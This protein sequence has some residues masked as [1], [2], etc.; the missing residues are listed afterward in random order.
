[1][2]KR[3]LSMLLVAAMLISCFPALPITWARAESMSGQSGTVVPSYQMAGNGSPS[4]KLDEDAYH[5]LGFD[6]SMGTKDESVLGPGN[7]TMNTKHEL[8]LNYNGYRNY[9]WVLRENLN[10]YHNWTSYHDAGAYKYYGQFYNKDYA[11]LNAGNGYTHGVLGG[12]TLGSYI[13]SENN[14]LTR[15]FELSTAFRSSSGKE[16][17]VAQIYINSSSVRKDFTARLELI[18]FNNGSEQIT[19]SVTLSSDLYALDEQGMFYN[20]NFDALF[21]IAAGDFNGDGIDEI[22]VYFATGDVKIYSTKYDSLSLWKTIYRSEIVKNDN[23]HKIATDGSYNH[24]VYRAP[25]VTLT[26]GDLKKDHSDDLII[27][28][29][30]PQGDGSMVTAHQNN[31]YTYIYG[32]VDGSLK[33]EK[34]I[35]LKADLDGS[36]STPQVFKG[37]NATVGDLDGNNL[38]ELVI[39]GRLCNANNPGDT[40]WNKGGL[41]LVVY[42]HASKSYKVYDPQVV[43]LNEYDEADILVKAHNGDIDYYAPVAMEIVD[44]DGNAS[45]APYL[46][47]FAELFSYNRDT[48]QFGYTGHYIDTIKN[49]TNNADESVGKGQH[50]ISD[51]VVGNLNNNDRNAQQ[52]IAI[53]GCKSSKDDTYWYYMSYLSKNENGDLFRGVEGIMN[54][55]ISCLN[56]SDK[57]RS[58]VYVSISLPDVDNDSVM[59]KYLDT[60]SVYSKPEV[61]AILQ[62]V[63]YFQ[64]V[65]DVYDNYL[66]NGT[67]AYGKASGSGY[68]KQAVVSV[69]AGYYSE[70]HISAGVASNLELTIGAFAD[71]NYVKNSETETSIEYSGD[72][73]DDYVVMYTIPYFYHYY[74]AVYPD[75][76]TNIIV[77]EEPMTPATVIVPVDTYDAIANKTGALQPIRGNILNSIPGKPMT[78]TTPPKGEWTSIGQ[79]QALTNAGASGSLVTVSHTV[80]NSEEHNFAAGIEGELKLGFGGGVGGNDTVHGF[81][82]DGSVGGG[83]V[84][85]SMEGVAYTGSVDNLPAGV[86]GYGFNWQLGISETTLNGESIIVV[87][88]VTSNVKQAPSLPKDL[89]VTDITNRSISLQWNSA[90]EAAVYELFVSRDQSTWLPLDP[91][92]ATMVDENNNMNYQVTD[93]SPGTTYYF[94]VN[95]ADAKGVRSLDSLPV[96]GT[97]LG[98]DGAFSIVF[99]PQDTSAAKGKDATFSVTVSSDSESTIY[100]QWMY[101]AGSG[102]VNIPNSNSSTLTVSNVTQDMDGYVYRC[103]VSQSANYFY[104]TGAKLTV[105]KTNIGVSLGVTIDGAA[106]ADGSTVQ[107]T[108]VTTQDVTNQIAVWND[109]VKNGY[110][111]VTP[112]QFVS[113]SDGGFSYS[114]SAIYFWMDAAGSLYQN[115]SG[116]SVG[117]KL[118]ASYVFSSESNTEFHTSASAAAV[119]KTITVDKDSEKKVSVTSGF[120]VNGSSGEYVYIHTSGDKTVYY[121]KVGTYAKEENG[122]TTNY[123]LYGIVTLNPDATYILNTGVKYLVNELDKVKA[124]ATQTIVVGQTSQTVPG[125]KLV[126]TASGLPSDLSAKDKVTFRVVHTSSGSTTNITATRNGD[127]WVG[128]HTFTGEGVYQISA[129]YSGNEVYFGCTSN[130]VTLFVY[131]SRNVMTLGGATMYYGQTLH[132][133]P[134][135]HSASGSNVVSGKVT[136]TVKQGDKDVSGLVSGGVFTPV[137]S[138]EYGITASCTVDGVQYSASA[139]I[140][141]HAKRLTI[142]ANSVTASLSDSQQQRQSLLSATVS[143]LLAA[144]AQMLSY[145]VSSD[146]VKA[147][148]QGDYRIV[149]AI[150][151]DRAAL[152]K[153]YDIVIS[154]GT[155]TLEQSSVRVYADAVANGVVVISYS[156]IVSDSTGTY[157]STPLTVNSGTLLPLGARVT[158]TASPNAGFGVEKWTLNGVISSNSGNT[159]L[160]DSLSETVDIDV[161]FTQNYSTLTFGGSDGG[162]ITGAYFGTNSS[163]NSGDRINLNQTVVL[164]AKPAEGYVVSSWTCDG[165]IVKAENGV[166]NFT[167]LSLKVS[168]VAESTVYHVNFEPAK[169]AQVTITFLD[170]D[171]Y[172]VLGGSV[173]MNQQNISGTDGVFVFDTYV[174]DNL[175]I[176][177]S[178]PGNMLIDHWELDGK[179]CANAV[180]MLEINDLAGDR[181]YV[182]YCT[183]PNQRILTLGT[184]LIE[185]NGGSLGAAGALEAMRGNVSVASGTQLPQGVVVQLVA[186]PAAGYRVTKW[187]INGVQVAGA[188]VEAYQLLL[189]QDSNVQVW[190]EKEPII[191]F[192]SGQGGN[193]NAQI[194]D[195]GVA[196]GDFVEFGSNIQVNFIPDTGYVVDQVFVDGANVTNQLRISGDVRYIILENIQRNTE[197][198]ASYKAKPVVTISGSGITVEGFKDFGAV[199]LNSGDYV[200]FGSVLSVT[201]TPISG[202]VVNTIRVNGAAVD[203]VAAVDSDVVNV[204]IDDIQTDTEISVVYKTK[205]IVSLLNPAFGQVTMEATRD[206]AFVQIQ[207]GN[208]VDFG[209]SVLCTVVPDSGYVVADVTADG[210]SLTLTAQEGTDCVTFC[211]ED[212]RKDTQIQVVYDAKPVVSVDGTDNGDVFLM[213]D[214]DFANVDISSGDYVDFGANVSG[215]V[216]PDFGFIV[217]SVTVNGVEVALLAQNGTDAVIFDV[218]DIQADT[219]I[220]VQYAAIDTTGITFGIVDKN[221]VNAD[222]GLDGTITASVDRKGMTAYAVVNDA[223]GVLAQVYSGSTVTFTAIPNDGYKVS[224]WFVNG[225][226]VSQQ[227]VLIISEDMADQLVEVQFDLIGE[228]IT[229]AITGAQ[230]K[231]SLS[232]TFKPNGGTT[233]SFA[234]G[235]QPTTEGVIT[236]TLTNLDSNYEVEGWYVD[237]QK[238]EGASGL[239]F[240]YYPTVDVGADVTVKLIRCSYKVEFSAV[241]GGVTAVVGNDAITSGDVIVGDTEVTFTAVP[242]EPTGYSFVGWTI[243]GVASEHKEETL[244]ISLVEDVR[245]QAIYE[246]DHVRYTVTYGVVDGNGT[247][248]LQGYRYSPVNIRAGSDLTFVATPDA[249]YRVQGWYSD[250]AGTTAISGTKLEQLNYSTENLVAPMTVYVKFEPIPEYSIRVDVT[251]LGSVVATVNGTSAEI[252][253]GVLMVQRYDDVVLSAV[254]NNDHYLRYWTLDQVNIG[255]ELTL[256]LDSVTADMVVTAQFLP[257]QSVEIKTEIDGGDIKIEAGFNGELEEIDPETG[258]IIHKGQDVVITV[259]PK[260]G[261]MLDKWIINGVEQTDYLAHS[262]TIKEMGEDTEIR[263]EFVDEVLHDVPEAVEGEY[264]IVDIVESP[265]QYGTNQQVRDRGDVSFVVHSVAPYVIASISVDA[266]EGST[267]TVMRSRSVG[268]AWTVTVKNAKSDIKITEILYEP[269]SYWTEEALA[270]NKTYLMELGGKEVGTFTFNQVDGG[271]TILDENGQYLAIVNKALTTSSD[272]FVWTYSNGC[273]SAVVKGSSNNWFGGW[274]GSSRN[275]TYYLVMDSALSISTSNSN[276]QAVFLLYH[277]DVYHTFQD[278]V[279][280]PTCGDRGYTTHICVNCG[281]T[282]VDTYVSALGHS[283]EEKVTAPTCE[284]QGFTK[285]TCIH[286]GDSYTTDVVD[287]LNHNYGAVVF[288]ATCEAQGYTQYTCDRCGD[289]YQGDFVSAL[290]HN[291]VDGV[292]E[293]CGEEEVV[294]PPCVYLAQKSLTSGQKYILMLNGKQVGT[295]TFRQVSGGWTI[296]SEDGSYLALANKA[297]TYS[298]TAFTWTYSNNRFSVV[299]QGSTSGGS[300]GN[301]WGS[302]R[303]TTYYLVSSGS[304]IGVATSSSGATASFWQEVSGDHVYGDPVANNGMHD[305]TCVNCGNVYSEACND[306]DC[307]LCNPPIPEAVIRVSVDVT[308]KSSGGSWGNWWGSSSSRTTYT[309]KITASAE[310]AQIQSVAYSTNGGS[311]WTTGTSFT[312]SSKIESFRIR[313]TTTDGQVFY[314]EYSNG[315]VVSVD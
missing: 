121:A 315:S 44:L 214:K 178:V 230:D 84:K 156:T 114:A 179:V 60:E 98:N 147:V 64:D 300:W 220:Q 184:Q 309:A 253:D 112:K 33:K 294:I 289:S 35:P 122:T 237:G 182:V 303:N 17:R 287:A 130:V 163:F 138:G 50:W 54:A 245:V 151:S 93:L 266:G 310:N 135:I 3:L 207:S 159:Y 311:S 154:S 211:A 120:A 86:T 2:K 90:T 161:Y 62:S 51:V 117:S 110:T 295:F 231:A 164:T 273:F 206:F 53:I 26:T 234:S 7:T 259:T 15:V 250:A 45:E 236:F 173:N 166:D 143:G 39:G 265:E 91:I 155:F 217:K 47:F 212:I 32:L 46:F 55:V 10:L 251:G 67:T 306:A 75:G 108:V 61:Q 132:L 142:S 255:N 256:Q 129:V 150:S 21:D 19:S 312:S 58:S 169:E 263:V 111:K 271:W 187:T 275:T 70:H 100:Y 283:Y 197:I 68:G 196:S 22:A 218:E 302:S 43:D 213:A 235:N 92:P 244:T 65:A 238:Q 113:E 228:G 282:Y 171:G 99:Q 38:M 6:T 260:K 56:R 25:I 278:T 57:S 40:G 74:D 216:V 280:A 314:F 148:T 268:S 141:V 34:E 77:I 127:V 82:I 136:Y 139:K 299:V 192:V 170:K 27:N 11:H 242:Q 71:Y 41:I 223:S 18:R 285:H 95:A 227:P 157:T 140:V 240:Q 5:A 103:R 304:G 279:T 293:R 180:D 308:S 16:D 152:E 248:T 13:K 313:V 102:W 307:Q 290:N 101:N 146:A 149:V 160:I 31:P 126:L 36:G 229:Y 134:V 76:S 247:L 296:Q 115:T 185:T 193:V 297:L 49:Q 204:Q 8:Y 272:A 267:V 144:D 83:F 128:E 14:H 189:D 201:V 94:K 158:I 277:E 186:Q 96:A 215:T 243:N 286:C 298:N 210:V 202:Y 190:F 291:Y 9:G 72:A 4:G 107:A 42:D 52:L 246:L 124:S 198:T 233:Q 20:Q 292:C 281:Y 219:Q 23:W 258:I 209:T 88:Y 241:E 222:G 199:I 153:K 200:D 80:T 181:A 81:Y 28:V 119:S 203:F 254:P 59:L 69:S 118:N 305:A 89:T 225:Q 12:N 208:Y 205:P 232:A 188:D 37:A 274:W 73:G 24:A 66:N 195:I 175:Q 116:G 288:H 106:I 191:A 264:T 79:V 165:E 78:Y 97:T 176:K 249:G 162:T 239:T 276:A 270:D 109:V 1:M 131:G 221:G 252:V 269:C 301:R 125:D 177:I 137:E 30:M 257:S 105:S 87:G 133:Q 48:M 226:E 224:K 29:S 168:G 261:K 63:P 194:D 183:S 85:S 167:G 174:H 123:D 262:L 284:N 145:T 104:S 172:P